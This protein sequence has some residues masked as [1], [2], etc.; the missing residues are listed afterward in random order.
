MSSKSNTT[1]KT[2]GHSASIQ[3]TITKAIVSQEVVPHMQY[4]RK[5]EDKKTAPVMTHEQ[6]TRELEYQIARCILKQK[7]KRGEITEMDF[8]E[9]CQE[10]IL[11][12]DPPIERLAAKCRKGGETASHQVVMRPA[13]LPTDMISNHVSYSV[14]PLDLRNE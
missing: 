8:E 11:L 3:K 10:F 7:L 14:E 12:C 9:R 13:A 1:S 6:F 5:L 2:M 4:A